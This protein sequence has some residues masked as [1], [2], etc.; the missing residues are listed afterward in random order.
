VLT[1]YLISNAII[2][3][4]TAWFGS[5][6]GR[7]RFLLTCIVL[8]TLASAACGA[9]GSLGF[10]IAARVLQGVGGGA[11]QP[12]AQ[13]VL[14]E[15]FPPARRGMAMAVFSMGVIVAPI[16]GPTLGGWITDN[17]SWRWVFYIN[18]PIGVL[19][20]LMTYGFVEDPP[21]I[22]RGGSRAMDYAGFGLLAVWLGTAQVVFDKGQ[23]DDW[24]AAPWIRWFVAISL[25]AMVAFIVRE[26]TAPDPIVDLR[27]LANRNFAAGLVGVGLLGFLLFGTTSQLPLFLQTLLG[28]PALQSGLT[29]SPRGLGAMG[30]AF[31]IGRAIGVVDSRILIGAGFSLLALSSFLYGRLDLEIAMSNVVWASIINGAATGMIFVPLSTMA[32]GRLRNTQIANAAGLYNLM[33]N[34]GG[35][36]G[37]SVVTTLLQRGAQAHQAALVAHLTPYDPA[38]QE[39]LARTEAALAAK[40]G[41]AAPDQALGLL[42]RVLEQQATLMAFVDSFRLIGLMALASVALVLL[43]GKVSRARPPAAAH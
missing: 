30:S 38:Y 28:Y 43:F 7:R 1:S 9:A 34:L 12:I 16:L 6:F 29:V 18:L 37:I 36:V 19:A 40:S 13:A 41:P 2:L 3:P 5:I 33:R 17:Y 21:Y 35:S 27:I 15:S 24:F 26:M 22:G 23:Q 4:A 8:F 11:L 10:L 14:L 25:V 31:L 32:M 42:H 20:L 39:W